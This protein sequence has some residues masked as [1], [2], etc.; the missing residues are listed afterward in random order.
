MAHDA[1]TLQALGSF[2]T[3]PQGSGA[4]FWNG[5]AG[6]AA[7]SDG[8]IY[9]VSANGD[10][11]GIL[12][13]DGFDEEVLRLGPAPLMRVLDSFTPF[14]KDALN[15]ADLD[16]GSSGALIHPMPPVAPRTRMFCSL[17]GRKAGCICSTGRRW[18]AYRAEPTLAHWHPYRW[19]RRPRLDRPRTS[20]GR[21]MWLPK[22]RRCS[23]SLFQTLIW[24]HRPRRRPRSATT[25]L[26]AT[27][28]ISANGTNDG[29]VWINVLKDGGELLAY[30]ANG[31]GELFDSNG[32][33]DAPSYVYTEFTTPTIA[34]GKVF[35]PC[36]LEWLFSANCPAACQR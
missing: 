36:T 20:T 7:D 33:P 35:V 9:A 34:D 4:S 6:P 17:R 14:N 8:S 19:C 13:P 15:V 29:I 32:Q 11:G 22:S 23:N 3:T 18:A 16:L 25:A 27:P 2:N 28:S 30:D 1:T 21:S 12:T 26:G 24:L 10:I 31:L 5:G